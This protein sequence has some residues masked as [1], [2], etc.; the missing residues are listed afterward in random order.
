[1]PLLIFAVLLQLMLFQN[2]KAE[3]E[4]LSNTTITAIPG[5]RVGHYTDPESLK[6]CTVIRFSEKGATAA[7]DVR[8]SA[9]GTRETD[10]LDP[11]NLV[12]KIHAI[13]LSGGSAY[14]LDAASGVM[15][16]L[17]KENVGFPVGRGIVVPIVPAAVLFDLHIGNPKVRPSSTWGFQACKKADAS[18]VKMGN[19]GAGT[20]ATV[21][22]L[23][24]MDRAMKSGLGSAVQH[25][26]NG[27]LVGA[28]VAVNALGDIVNPDNGR[29][30]AGIRGDEKGSFQSSVKVLFEQGVGNLFAGANT[31]IGMVATNI[32]L[33]K[34]QLKKVAQMAHDGVARATSPA[35]TMYDGDTIFAVSVP[36][37][38]E[39]KMTASAG[40][41]NL[42]GTAA[43]EVMAKA[44]INAVKHVTTVGGCPAASDWKK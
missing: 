35:H 9:P 27:V 37:Q 21:G 6:G 18:P 38:Q 23:L 25:F 36:V 12:D 43:A 30:I 44:I 40:T 26:S 4:E 19:V 39:K 14:G 15:H 28:I 31:T 34:T 10:L 8:G 32:P 5:I 29:I 3:S 41:V 2:P 42:V 17:E 22:K 1:M 7:V 20:G 16:C 24:G 13:V 33:C 11:I